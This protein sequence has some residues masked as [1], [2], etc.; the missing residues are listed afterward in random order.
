MHSHCHKHL[1][2]LCYSQTYSQTIKTI[3]QSWFFM[4]LSKKRTDNDNL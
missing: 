1:Q 3:L 2:N 4:K